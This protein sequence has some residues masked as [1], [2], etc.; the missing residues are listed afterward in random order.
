MHNKKREVDKVEWFEDA[1]EIGWTDAQSYF[2]RLLLNIRIN[3]TYLLPLILKQF[4]NTLSFY[5]I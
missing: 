5:Y 4:S 2:L 3:S 1:R